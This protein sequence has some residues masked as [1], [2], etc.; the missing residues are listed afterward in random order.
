MILNYRHRVWLFTLMRRA[1]VGS[2]TILA[3]TLFTCVVCT[4]CPACKFKFALA[5]GG[6]MHFRCVHCPTEFCSGCGDLFK[7]V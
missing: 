7:R 4:E 2:W 5:K 1:L 3:A 6:C